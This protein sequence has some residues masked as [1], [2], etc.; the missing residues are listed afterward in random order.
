TVAA[1]TGVDARSSHAAK[2]ALTNAAARMNT[3][4]KITLRNLMFF[5]GYAQA[6]RPH[7]STSQASDVSSGTARGFDQPDRMNFAPTATAP[8]RPSE[9]GPA[10]RIPRPTM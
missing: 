3:G 7:E 4:T 8:A 2:R 9:K 10:F 1:K 5:C 6:T